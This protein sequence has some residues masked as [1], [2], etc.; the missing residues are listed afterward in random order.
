MNWTDRLALFAPLD[1]VALGTLFCVWLVIGWRIEHASARQPS[2][3][4]IMANYRREW[5]QQMLT[6]EPRI[7]DAQT[8]ATLRQGTSFF[9]STSMIA[10][11]GI[12]AVIG[13]ANNLAV[14]AQDLTLAAHPPIVWEIKLLLV[15]FFLTNAFLK[16]VWSNRLFGYCSVIMG[17]V[18]NDPTDPRA[19]EMAR[20]AGELNVTAARSF[21]RGL[22]AV[23]FSLAS[24]CWLGGP[25][26]LL[27]G[28]IMTLIVIWRREFAS[29][30]RGILL[31]K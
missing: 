28:A 15:V 3:S 13:N 18:P 26:L 9:A 6:R 24:V 30:S 23:Y 2:V 10:I 8:I 12:L 21:N 4:M 1:F 27:A 19:P 25:V 17:A 31:E 7:F 22:R 5:M 11:G 29:Q 16:F 20:K 14:V